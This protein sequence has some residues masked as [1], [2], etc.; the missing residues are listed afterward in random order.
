M[1]AHLIKNSFQFIDEN[2]LPVI[3]GTVETYEPNGS[4][5]PKPL[6]SDKAIL[7]SVGSTQTL[8]SLGMFTAELFESL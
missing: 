1:P 3:G 2:G 8:N 4:S 5:T 7:T 6:Y